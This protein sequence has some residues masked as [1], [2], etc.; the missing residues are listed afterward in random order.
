MNVREADVGM[1]F[2]VA[3]EVKF[4]V[5]PSSSSA[6]CSA[7]VSS[8]SWY[9][10]CMSKKTYGGECVQKEGIV[11]RGKMDQRS[12][13]IMLRSLLLRLYRFNR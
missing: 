2:R 6:A 8:F 1:G 7:V 10:L 5:K 4:S 9:E 13:N 12:I 11:G 3:A